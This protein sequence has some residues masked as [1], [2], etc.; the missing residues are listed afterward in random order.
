MK[1][2]L[3]Q[4]LFVSSLLVLPALTASGEEFVGS[5]KTVEGEVSLQRGSEVTTVAPGVR[6]AVGDTLL[7]GDDGAVGVLFRDDSILT[8]GPGSSIVIEE[9]LFEPAEGKLGF[10]GLI[11]RGTVTYLSGLITKLS[12]DSVRLVT[13]EATI[14]IRGTFLAL[15]V[16]G[17]G[18]T[19]SRP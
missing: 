6:I 14:G 19:G 7:T 16:D 17:Q 8:L 11:T 2:T 3:F 13:P 4:A 9:F 12:P 15:Q 10:L 1:K 5:V 18:E